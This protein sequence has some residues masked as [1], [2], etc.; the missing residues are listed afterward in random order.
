MHNS[1]C[2][3]NYYWQPDLQLA[4]PLYGRVLKGLSLLYRW[5]NIDLSQNLYIFNVQKSFYRVWSPL[6]KIITH[7]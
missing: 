7:L 6:K 5:V 1:R 2:L 3:L 4:F